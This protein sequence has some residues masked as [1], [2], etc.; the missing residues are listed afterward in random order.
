MRQ[1]KIGILRSITLANDSRKGG[2]PT[3]VILLATAVRMRTV[4]SPASSMRTSFPACFKAAAHAKGKLA[5]VGFSEPH[6]PISKNFCPAAA[7][8]AA[9]CATAIAVP[10][11]APAHTCPAFWRNDLRLGIGL[12]QPNKMIT[13]V[14][15][16]QAAVRSGN[17]TPC[18]SGLLAC[19]VRLT[20]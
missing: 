8:G 20:H 6:N 9:G 17:F 4:A 3:G 1:T 19:P 12:S 15:S 2:Q 7:S 5:L 13:G 16:R 11:I 10:A 18:R 14:I